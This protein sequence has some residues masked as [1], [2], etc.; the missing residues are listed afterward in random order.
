MKA[1]S[2]KFVGIAMLD[3]AYPNTQVY[4]Y[5][6]EPSEPLYRVRDD[7]NSAYAN[8]QP[9]YNEH[10]A[11]PPMMVP[12]HTRESVTSGTS[13][14]PMSRNGWEDYLRKL[15]PGKLFDVA[16]ATGLA[17][18]NQRAADPD[19]PFSERDKMES[20]MFGC[21]LVRAVPSN[22]K[23]AIWARI[24]TLDYEAG[25]PA[26]MPTYEEDPTKV[27]K[28][29][30]IWRGGAITSRELYYPVVA[31]YDCFMRWDWLE[32]VSPEMLTP[33]PP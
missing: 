5:V 11:G 33:P 13:R 3:I 26:G 25:P 10:L 9:R 1:T 8:Y 7:N 17:M 19:E 30:I 31:R 22:E 6:A 27:Q 23:P 15:N 32:I 16:V 28:F 24:L 21:N 2:A 20:L 12:M 4:R 14:T 18:F 29:T